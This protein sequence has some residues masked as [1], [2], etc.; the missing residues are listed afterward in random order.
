MPHLVPLLYHGLAQ[1]LI[2][3]S[4]HKDRVRYSR[5]DGR[6]AAAH[7]KRIS[8]SRT[9]MVKL[10]ADELVSRTEAIDE[11]LAPD[12]LPRVGTMPTPTLHSTSW[13]MASDERPCTRKRGAG[14]PMRLAR[15]QKALQGAGAVEADDVRVEHL[16]KPM[17]EREARESLAPQP[18][19]SGRCGMD[20]GCTVDG[21]GD[22]RRRLR[23]SN[24]RSH[25]SAALPGRR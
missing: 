20:K 14:R 24:R 17:R 10:P 18:A 23:R 15:G 1:D 11:A 4:S 19:Q 25:R 9:Q 22:D 7:E 13:Q 12:E 6:P 8:L 21:A 2:F 3:Q 16:A 5:A